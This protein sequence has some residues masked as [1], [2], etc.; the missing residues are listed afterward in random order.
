MVIGDSHVR[1]LAEHHNHI[2]ERMAGI[3]IEFRGVGGTG[4]SFV[5]QNAHLA[6]G[7]NIVIIMTGGNDLANGKSIAHILGEYQRIAD[8][9]LEWRDVEA[10]LFTSI[11]PRQNRIFNRKAREILQEMDRRYYRHPFITAWAWDRRQPFKTYDGVHLQGRGY[12]R[13]ATY[14]VPAI[15]WAVYHQQWES[16]EPDSLF[17]RRY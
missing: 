11:W 10:V 9:Y 16:R 14:L 7:F 3:E 15:L 6:C 4:T 8:S 13:A 2:R 17:R 12:Q 1:R 5:L